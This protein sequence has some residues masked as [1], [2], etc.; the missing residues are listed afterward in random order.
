TTGWRLARTLER[1][2]GG[3]AAPRTFTSCPI[4]SRQRRRRRTRAVLGA[5]MSSAAHHILDVLVDH[6]IDTVY[7]IPG[8]A[9]SKLYAELALRDATTSPI[10]VINA[11]HET[12][13]MFL[14][15]GHALAT[16]RPAVV[17]TTAG[18]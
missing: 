12:N 1:M 9:I 8:G 14:A 13:A 16:G 10:R 7:G 5:L 11:V 6:G 2:C 18:P 4:L 15:M 17:L 3:R